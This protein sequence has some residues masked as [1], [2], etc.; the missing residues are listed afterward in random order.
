MLEDSI[1]KQASSVA[2]PNKASPEKRF[3]PS[4]SSE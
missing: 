1:A 4:G 2:A 3:S